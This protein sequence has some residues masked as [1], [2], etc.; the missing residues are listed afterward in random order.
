V[1]SLLLFHLTCFLKRI[2]IT[3]QDSH[4][5]KTAVNFPIKLD[6]W[7]LQKECFLHDGII[8]WFEELLHLTGN[9]TWLYEF[10]RR[11]WKCYL[12]HLAGKKSFERI[13]VLLHDWY[14]RRKISVLSLLSVECY[15]MNSKFITRKVVFLHLFRTSSVWMDITLHI[16]SQWINRQ[17]TFVYDYLLLV[18]CERHNSKFQTFL[19]N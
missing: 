6:L 9:C 14:S 1:D 12:I 2:Q 5:K 10:A 16:F 8:C 4:C 15:Q 19:A 3:V 18:L 7:I 13:I 11:Y 17:I